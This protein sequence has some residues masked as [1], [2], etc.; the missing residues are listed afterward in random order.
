MVLEQAGTPKL[1]DAVSEVTFSGAEALKA[2][3]NAWY[4]TTVGAFRLT[5]GGLVLEIIMPGL[6]VERDIR[7][8]CG[9]R[10]GLPPGGP[11]VAP[12]SVLTGVDYA[13]AWG[14]G[15]QR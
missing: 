14:V 8:N 12:A 9:V 11:V 1:I 15:A 10:F 2:G 3:K 5:P 7:P 13:L 4:V 6:D